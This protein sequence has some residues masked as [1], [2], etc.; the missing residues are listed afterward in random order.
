[1]FGEINEGT[2]MFKLAP[3]PAQLPAQSSVLPLHID[4]ISLN[5]DW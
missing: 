5:G 1:M 3:T 2:P 4:G